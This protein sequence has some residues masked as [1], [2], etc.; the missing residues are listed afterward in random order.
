MKRRNWAILAVF[1]CMTV[2]G[3]AGVWDTKQSASVAALPAEQS[4]NTKAAEQPVNPK[5]IAANTRL[6]FK[7]FQAILKQQPEKNIFISPASIAIALSMTYN[8]A[9]G[10]TQQAIAQTLE[11]QGMSLEDVNQG[12]AALRTALTNLDPEVQLSVANSLWARTGEPFYPE[13]L[14]KNQT[15]YN[16]KVTDL[17]FTDPK[18]PSIINAWVKQSTNGKIE[19]IVDRKEIEPTTILF[20]I[21][22][23]YFKGNWTKPFDKTQTKELPFTLLNGTQKPQPMMFQQAQYQYYTNPL[24]QAVMLPYG[25]G[26]LSLYIFLPQNNVSLK[27]FYQNLNAENWE[28]WMNQFQPELLLI[29]LPRFR[30]DYGLELDDTLKSLG[31]AIAFDEKRA[32]FTGMTSRR[33]AYISKVKHNTFF[34]VNEEGSQAAGA[35]SVRISTR[36]SPPH[37]VVDR[38]FF[39]V[40]RDNQTKSILFMGS[41]VEP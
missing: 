8:G 33:P 23:I 21:N 4:P 14:Q 31:M 38:P 2:W 41:V 7:L 11:L 37:L 36:A 30:L 10:E 24:F 15:F 13:F 32:N 5:L 25:Q 1:I 35:T 16:A 20:L 27:T 6:S 17:D 40:I 3:L 18:T 12:N 34:E 29:G 22:A 39:C 26:R 19:K 9:Q 28:Q